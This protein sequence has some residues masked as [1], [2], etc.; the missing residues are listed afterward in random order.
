MESRPTARRPAPRLYL[1][2]PEVVD[3]QLFAADLAAM[4]QATDVAAVLLRLAA[5]DERTRING[6]KAIAP[7]AQAAGAALLLAGNA[8]L[9]G[10][11]G[12]DG[13]HLWSIESLEA[14]LPT[15]R[16]GRIAGVGGLTTRHDAM[17][18]GEVG[19]DYVMFGDPDDQ[20]SPFDTVVDRVAWWAEIFEVPCVGY[21]ASLDEILPLVSAG[22]DFV[23]LGPWILSDPRG[24]AAAV[25]D[26]ATRLQSGEAVE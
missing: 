9:V 2:T 4:L 18:A 10:R 21:A 15:L 22:A 14:A 20:R 26:A 16:P 7:V 17:L 23:A 3:A 1:V 6:G 11:T 13:A 5:A 19:A 25:G 12:A 8:E 24:A